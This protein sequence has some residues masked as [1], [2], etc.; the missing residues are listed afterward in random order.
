MVLFQM[1]VQILSYL[2]MIEDHIRASYLS[3]I[4]YFVER[5]ES[6]NA[7]IMIEY[8]SDL[9]HVNTTIITPVNGYEYVQVPLQQHFFEG[10]V[11]DRPVS[12]PQ[13]HSLMDNTRFSIDTVYKLMQGQT[14]K[15]FFSK[16]FFLCEYHSKIFS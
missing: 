4:R 6:G 14:S 13:W 1:P 16:F 15:S 5:V 2:A 7:K 11:V 12:H 10:I 8:S 9:S 3:Y